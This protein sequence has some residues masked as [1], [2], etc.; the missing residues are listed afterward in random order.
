MALIKKSFYFDPTNLLYCQLKWSKQKGKSKY[1][2]NFY[3]GVEGQIVKLR[4]GFDKTNWK[5]V[6]K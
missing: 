6:K 5:N 4:S 2:N 1:I 3:D